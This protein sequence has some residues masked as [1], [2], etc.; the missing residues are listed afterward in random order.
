[1]SLR[2]L[3]ML[4]RPGYWVEEMNGQLYSAIVSYMGEKGLN[5]SELA[6]HLNI[7]KG[8]VSQILNNG[9]INY[10]MEKLVE[11]AI[12]VGK[13]PRFELHDI[14]EYE[15]YEIRR[16]AVVIPLKNQS[17]LPS[18]HESISKGGEYA[19]SLKVHSS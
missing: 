7:S 15:N 8:R 2:R 1:M 9:G 11:I 10:S 5:Q 14:L 18:G 12:K 19:H 4:K 6:K 17:T 3:R 16:D 13:F